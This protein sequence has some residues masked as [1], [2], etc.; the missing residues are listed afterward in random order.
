MMNAVSRKCAAVREGSTRR[1]TYGYGVWAIVLLA[2]I[3]LQAPTLEA[4]FWRTVMVLMMLVVSLRSALAY[5]YRA[6]PSRLSWWLRPT[7]PAEREF[8]VTWLVYA[9]VFGAAPL[10]V[11][12]I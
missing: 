1:L 3:A 12:L 4:W 5:A 8:T 2:T 9:V 10:A 6:Q 7:L 11:L